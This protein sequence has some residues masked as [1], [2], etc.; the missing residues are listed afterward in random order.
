MPKS[1][2]FL[3]NMFTILSVIYITTLWFKNNLF[4]ENLYI[5]LIIYLTMP[6]SVAR[7][8]RSF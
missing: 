4:A 5:A 2:R 1:F 3:I 6:V 7:P 8:E